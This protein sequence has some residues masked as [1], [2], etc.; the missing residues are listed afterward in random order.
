MVCGYDKFTTATVKSKK[1]IH[2]FDCEITQDW[3]GLPDRADLPSTFSIDY[4]RVGRST[5]Q[6]FPKAKGF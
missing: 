4:L 1:R 6:P 2:M 5:G 3:V